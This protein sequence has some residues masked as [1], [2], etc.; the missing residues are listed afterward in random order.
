[1]ATQGFGSFPVIS[2]NFAT[3]PPHSPKNTA[4]K[5]SQRY[6]S[7]LPPI[8]ANETTSDKINATVQLSL[9]ELDR[10]ANAQQPDSP[11]Y[12]NPLKELIRVNEEKEDTITDLNERIKQLTQT[13]L[14]EFN[15]LHDESESR[16]IEAAATIAKL[17]ATIESQA[18]D[19]AKV[20]TK[21]LAPSEKVAEKGIQGPTVSDIIQ[22]LTSL[23]ASISNIAELKAKTSTFRDTLRDLI[24]VSQKLYDAGKFDKNATQAE[25]TKKEKDYDLLIKEAQELDIVNVIKKLR[26]LEQNGETHVKITDSKALNVIRAL[27]AINQQPMQEI[28]TNRAAYLEQVRQCNLKRVKVEQT[29]DS[30]MLYF[31]NCADLLQSVK[32]FLDNRWL[33]DSLTSTTYKLPYLRGLRSASIS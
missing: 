24:G 8:P 6:K 14:N 30:C 9:A 5:P 3:P 20:Q 18:A 21:T 32:N 27:S 17:K 16:D 23:N 29:F 2:T 7:D 1:M 28:N 19:L 12:A 15:K 4:N 22:E 13:H 33:P 10:K 25:L 11:I 26:E 31:E